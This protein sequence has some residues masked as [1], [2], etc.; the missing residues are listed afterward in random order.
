MI[1]IRPMASALNTGTLEGSEHEMLSISVRK[2]IIK[3]RDST[4]DWRGD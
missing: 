1:D 4:N 2:E 3:H